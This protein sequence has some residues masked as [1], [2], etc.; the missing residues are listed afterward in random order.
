MKQPIDFNLKIVEKDQRRMIDWSCDQSIFLSA[1]Q[2]SQGLYLLVNQTS[3]G[4]HEI[5]NMFLL[6][7]CKETLWWLN[8]DIH[9]FTFWNT[10]MNLGHSLAPIVHH[11][12]REKPVIQKRIWN[13]AKE[14]SCCAFILDQNHLIKL[15]SCNRP[16]AL[17]Q[18]LH[19][20]FLSSKLWRNLIVNI[21]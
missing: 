4:F 16:G 10:M 12:S 5:R 14:I 7:K 6:H 19:C 18:P 21:C 11:S 17:L 1:L 9:K 3:M 15:S 8:L 20:A 13:H 2:S